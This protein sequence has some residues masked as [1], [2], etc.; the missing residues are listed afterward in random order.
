MAALSPAEATRPIDPCSPAAVRTARKDLARNCDPRSLWTT[1]T[2]VGWRRATA[3][4]RAVTA[5]WSGHPLVDG[6][7]DD[8]VAEQV[9]DRAAVDLALRGGVLGDVGRPDPVG[10]GRGEVPLD[11]VVVHRRPG[12][13]AAAAPALA[14]GG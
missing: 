2:P 6:V 8:A 12:R 14:D 7:A 13:F 11:V 3:V 10:C 4:R 9:L 1:T 5:S